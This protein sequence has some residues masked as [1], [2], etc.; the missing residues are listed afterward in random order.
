MARFVNAGHDDIGGRPLLFFCFF[1][2][3]GDYDV[4]HDV[5]GCD[6]TVIDIQENISSK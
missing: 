4:G 2:D 5:A 6:S 3:V 1:P